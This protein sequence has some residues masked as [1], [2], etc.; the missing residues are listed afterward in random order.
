MAMK[1]TLT[2]D[3][4]FNGPPD[5]GN[6]GYVCGMVANLI[7]GT[8]EVT[9]RKPPPLDK[10]MKIQQKPEGTVQIMDGETLVATGRPASLDLQAPI[11]PT[12]A[13][14]KAAVHN[15]T[16]FDFHIFP[17]CFVCGPKRSE[18]DGLQ[19]YP[20]RASGHNLVASPWTPAD[21][22]SDENGRVRPQFIWAALDCP[23]A[24]AV[25][26]TLDMP[27]VLGRLTARLSEPIF[28][29]QEYIISGW[30]IG[31]DGRKHYAG[32]A[33]YTANGA[34]CALGQA[35]WIAI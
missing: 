29:G 5:S 31:K 21:D 24:F 23:G 11:S 12:M 30:S 15:Y 2:I 16:G 8:A 35:T 22:L 33:V 25:M 4:R 10:P 1:N 34:L 18:G 17:T 3:G 27:I 26:A 20:G 7:E 9:L 28:S 19:I 32:T 6:G 14:A 13:E